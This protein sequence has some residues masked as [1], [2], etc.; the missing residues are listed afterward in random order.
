MSVPDS[1][2]PIYALIVGIDNWVAPILP[3]LKGCAHD[4]RLMKQVFQE[5]FAVP[6]ENI[7]TLIDEQ[8]TRKDLTSAFRTHLIERAKEWSQS[9]SNEPSPAFVFHF[10]GHGSRARDKTGTQPDGL[11][12]TIVPQDSRTGDVFDIKDWELAKWLE[13]LT[14]YTDNVTVILDCCHSGSGTRNTE[15]T[16]IPRHGPTDW[17]P[18]PEGRPVNSLAIGHVQN[19][20]RSADV[21]SYAADRYV[22]L[23]ACRNF[24][25]AEEYVIQRHRSPTGKRYKHGAFTWFL[26]NELMGLPNDASVTYQELFRRVRYKVHRKYPRQTPQCEGARDRLLFG[27][28]S[29]ITDPLASVISL[30]DNQVWVDAG[31]VH[32]VTAGSS[33][34]IY[35]PQTRSLA[36]AK[37]RIC[38]VTVEEVE[39]TRCRC[40]PPDSVDVPLHGRVQISDAFTSCRKRIVGL[41]FDQPLLR[42][43]IGKLF[44]EDPLNAYVEIGQPE[45]AADFRISMLDNHIAIRDASGKI[46]AQPCS[47][48]Q[49]ETLGND[50]VSLCRYQNVLDLHNPNLDSGLRD[51]L[52]VEMFQVLG[53]HETGEGKSEHR[54]VRAVEP[55]ETSADGRPIVEIGKPIAIKVTNRSDQAV[56]CEAISFGYD[57]AIV[58]LTRLLTSAGTQKRVNPGG[59]LWFGRDHSDR[60]IV[61]SLPSDAKEK[62]HFT[63]A[64]EFLKVVA[65]LDEADFEILRQNGI[66][67]PHR[68]YRGSSDSPLNALFTQATA[69]TRALG[70]EETAIDEH[71][72]ATVDLEY[73]VTRPRE[74]L[75]QPVVGGQS[76]QIPGYELQLASPNG[77]DC[78]VGILTTTQNVRSEN[79]IETSRPSSPAL[80]SGSFSSIPISS[81]RPSAVDGEALFISAD[82]SV[83]D[84]LGKDRTLQ[85]KLETG[86]TSSPSDQCKVAIA[87]DGACCYPVATSQTSTFDL[88]WLPARSG[89]QLDLSKVIG[90]SDTDDQKRGLIRTAKL[91]LFELCGIPTP[92]LGLHSVRFI[93]QADRELAQRVAGGR[94]VN[95]TK[96]ELE[97]SKVNGQV[98]AR[99]ST[100]AL[101][102]HSLASDSATTLAD[103]WS[104]LGDQLAGYDHLFAFDYE[105]FNTSISKNGESLAKEL[106]SAKF[107]VQDGAQLDVFAIGMGAMV[108]RSMV[109]QFGGEAFVD[110]CF[111]AGCPNQGSN[112]FAFSK[113]IPWLATALLNVA[114]PS[115]VSTFL[116]AAIKKIEA[117]AVSIA[118]LKPDSEFL[119]SVNAAGRKRTIPYHSIAGRFATDHSS[120][121]PWYESAMRVADFGMN[122][123]FGGNHDLVVDVSSMTALDGT[124]DT[125]EEV[126]ANHFDYFG[127]LEVGKAIAKFLGN[128]PA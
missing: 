46:L 62:K 20:T 14:S 5:R 126:N 125:I 37:E 11:D 80:E 7:L 28:A 8:A 107:S 4:V 98:P 68:H 84:S 52:S 88:G 89:T 85:L 43:V 51:Q 114:G 22:L 97:L 29:V 40:R 12:E 94:R 47:T 15:S 10:S 69:G 100:C 21:P 128:A 90:P 124:N 77:V 109:E 16:G 6:E 26:A 61:F 96:G 121:S 119:R 78:R 113:A 91:Y 99:G 18:Q 101:I 66:R 103:L 110:R 63:E 44:D 71:D 2:P 64:T 60:R 122:A 79:S 49:I 9:Q 95:V 75:G 45:S 127:N 23:A 123:F 73:I 72:W 92:E 120:A 57:Y 50:I 17:R 74:Q 13:E 58:P 118:D 39:A 102:V 54:R 19:G 33:L 82:E 30:K 87:W 104:I 108:T 81:R 111:L 67:L 116:S 105:S 42:E 48:D 53:E 25:Y 115:P 83:F 86:I 1:A 35:P 56:Y 93:P 36:D 31:L 106:S 38:R 55:I 27:G 65:T 59:T 32:G 70:V 76:C 41:E 117:D 112:L 24:E 34:A 3:D